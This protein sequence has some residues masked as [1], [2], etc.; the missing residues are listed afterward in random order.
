MVETVK[1]TKESIECSGRG[2]CDRSAGTCVCFP[3]YD[4]SDGKDG[5]GSKG[6][7]AHI[8]PSVV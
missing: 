7:C 1:G 5:P 4:S 2:S 3:G 8:M 6:D